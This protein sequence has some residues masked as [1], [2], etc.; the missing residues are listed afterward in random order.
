MKHSDQMTKDKS[1]EIHIGEIIV[2][3]GDWWACKTANRKL[4][5]LPPEIINS[6]LKHNLITFHWFWNFTAVII[7][8]KLSIYKTSPTQN[9]KLSSYKEIIEEDE[10]FSVHHRNIQ[11]LVIV[12][13]Q[14][15]HGQSRKI[16]T[17]IITQ[18]TQ[19]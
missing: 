8:R 4:R 6:L 9:D 7:A 14:I 11:S 15:K 2:K 19:E 17:D 12:M 13:L 5:V 18:V 16:V 1:S 3:I 10:S